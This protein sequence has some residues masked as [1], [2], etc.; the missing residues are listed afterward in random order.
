MTLKLQTS[1]PSIV[2]VGGSLCGL[3]AANLLYR[4]G[5]DVHVYEKAATDLESRGAGL[6][7]QPELLEVLEKAGVL[8]DDSIGVSIAERVVFLRD[9]SVAGTRKYPQIYTAWSTLYHKLRQALPL[10]RYHLDKHFVGL[11]QDAN[12][13]HVNF[14]DG[15]HV[16]A[17]LMIAADGVHS[18]V[19][20]ILFP[21]ISLQYAGYVAWRGMVEES[22]LSPRVLSELFPYIG[23]SLPFHEQ[24]LGY[25][26]PGSDQSVRVGE[27]RYNFVWYRPAPLQTVLRDLLTDETGK[28]WQ[29]GIPPPLI[30]AEIIEQTR[31]AAEQL[32]PP[33][34]AEIIDKTESLFFQP[35]FDMTC[36]R[37]V[38]GRVALMG[39]A[40]FIARPHCAMGTT[41]AAGDAMAMVNAL[42]NHTDLTQA[43]SSYES[44][45]LR[46]GNLVMEH[47]RELGAYMQVASEGIDGRVMSGHQ[48]TPEAIMRDIGVPLESWYDAR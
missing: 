13:V 26:V 36:E 12:S 5:W 29:E 47:A 20:H 30:R 23:F 10:E 45:R 39:D 24:I 21:D 35:V 16:T 37:L 9:G 4:S 11:T 34:F 25:P 41:K 43:L 38:S 15:S 8:I 2:V 17:D 1:S 6:V 18:S 32:M 7:I 19:R 46:F 27:R 44:T 3:I 33:Q 40:A 28:Y 48:P 14:Q 42:L 22:V 31:Q